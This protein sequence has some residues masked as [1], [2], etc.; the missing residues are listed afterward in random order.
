MPLGGTVTI[1]V[2]NVT[3]GGAEREGREIAPGRFVM[4]AVRDTG[5]GMDA[6]TQ[7]RIFEPFFTTK[8]KAEGTGL[9]LAT[10]YGVVTQ[11]GGTIQVES[12]P[13]VGTTF[14]VYFPRVDPAG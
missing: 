3:L 12:E 8:E 11:S 14:F 13:G 4:L 6:G 10:A 1:E 7:A 5:H 2:G 9:G